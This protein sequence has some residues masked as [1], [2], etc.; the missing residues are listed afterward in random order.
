MGWRAQMAKRILVVEDGG[1]LRAIVVIV[2][3]QVGGYETI[4]AANGREAMEKAVSEKPDL[5]LMDVDLPDISGITVAKA[6][7]NNP[8][9]S[10]ILIIAQTGWASSRWKTTALAAGIVAYL[11]KPASRELIISTIERFL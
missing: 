4:E 9:T 2:L 10:H 1:D 3:R 5:I 11:Q 7:K 6:V 8:K